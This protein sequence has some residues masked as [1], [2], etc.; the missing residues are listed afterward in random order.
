M[1]NVRLDSTR[2]D[3]ERGT[4]I[5]DLL[6]SLFILY[7]IFQIIHLEHESWTIVIFHLDF[8]EFFQWFFEFRMLLCFDPKSK[9]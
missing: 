7:I 4:G 6:S 1:W 9:Y 3:E 8:D 2:F 5:T